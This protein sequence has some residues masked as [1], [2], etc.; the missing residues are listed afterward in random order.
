MGAEAASGYADMGPPYTFM[1]WDQR[2]LAYLPFGYESDFQ[3]TST[4]AAVLISA[5]TTSC[6][7]PSTTG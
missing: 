5:S 3:L 6:D 7:P 4:T 2:S 1:G